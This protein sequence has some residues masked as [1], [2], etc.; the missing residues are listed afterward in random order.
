MLWI[1]KS[2]LALLGQSPLGSEQVLNSLVSGADGHRSVPFQGRILLS[3]TRKKERNYNMRDNGKKPR[4]N[5]N[6]T[7]NM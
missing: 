1:N 6:E 7:E 3:V 4:K 5:A 2:G